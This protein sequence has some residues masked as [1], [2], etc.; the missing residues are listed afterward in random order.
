M[1]IT[2]YS[3]RL[4]SGETFSCRQIVAVY[5]LMC[6][7]VDC[8]SVRRIIQSFVVRTPYCALNMSAT[9]M[10]TDIGDSSLFARFHHLRACCSSLELRAQIN[11]WQMERVRRSYAL[12]HEQKQVDRSSTIRSDD[13]PSFSLPPQVIGISFSAV[14]YTFSKVI[15]MTEI[16]IA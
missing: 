11:Y 16:T 7:P 6:H 13:S 15:D 4:V 10:G 2:L 12:Q 14:N 9:M 5:L 3:Q 8:S 1:H